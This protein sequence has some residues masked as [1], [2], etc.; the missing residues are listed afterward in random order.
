MLLVNCAVDKIEKNE[1]GG[2]WSAYGGRGV[3][4]VFVMKPEGK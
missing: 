3:Y 1:M 4:R 2:A